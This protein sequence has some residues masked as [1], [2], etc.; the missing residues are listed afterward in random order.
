M[1][2]ITSVCVKKCF[3]IVLEVFRYVIAVTFIASGLLKGM[4]IE[5]TEQAVRG[6]IDLMGLPFDMIPLS[7]FSVLICVCEIII[8][9]LALIKRVF[10]LIHP[11]YTLIIGVFTFITYL[12]ITSPFGGLESCGCFGEI[13]HLDATETFVKNLCLLAISITL[14]IAMTHQHKRFAI[15]T[16]VVGVLIL[17]TSCNHFGL[18]LEEIYLEEAME[19]A[20]DNRSELEKVLEYF[21][22]EPDTMKQKAARF[23]IANMPFHQSYIGPGIE[24]YDSAYLKMSREPLEFRDSVFLMLSDN[25]DNNTMQGIAD[26]NN[27]KAEYLISHINET[28]DTW[29]QSTWHKYFSDDMFFEYVLPYRVFTEQVS[30]WNT[31]VKEEFPYLTSHSVRSKR[32]IM[33]EAESCEARSA[34]IV[35]TES[36]SNGKMRLLDKD[37][38]CVSFQIKT[39]TKTKKYIS[40][41][42]TTIDKN[43][44][45]G[46]FLNERFVGN[47]QLRPTYSMKF[48]KNSHNGLEIDLPSGDNTLTIQHK[49]GIVGLDYMIVSHI[50]NDDIIPD[51]DYSKTYYRLS[52]IAAG[53][54][55]AFDTTEVLK[56]SVLQSLSEERDDTRLRLDYQGYKCWS[57]CEHDERKG[58]L[59]L[60]NQYCLT[61]EN[62]NA[63]QYTFLNGNHQKWIILP[64]GNGTVRLMSKDS[65]LSLEAVTDTDGARRIVQTSYSGKD[66][67][68][69]KLEPCGLRK[70]SSSIFIPGNSFDWAFKVFDVTDRYEWIAFKGNIM[71]KGTSLIKG[72]TG[73]C[74]DEAAFTVLLCRSIG[75]PAAVDFTPHWANRSQSHL[76]SVLIGPDG[77]SIPF[78]MGCAP[79]DTAHYYHPYLKPKVF[80]HGFSLNRKMAD[81][82]RNVKEYPQLFKNSD[83]IDVAEEYYVTSD[84]VRDAPKKEVGNASMAYI[85]VFDNRE[86]VPVY[87]GKIKDGKVIFKSMV[88]NV[89]YMAA[90]YK[91]GRIRPFGNPFILESGGKVRDLSTKADTGETMT[92]LR[93]YPFMGKQ[94]HFN[95]RMSGGRFQISD[96]SDFSN[97]TTF[98]THE[99]IT[100][101]NWYDITIGNPK[102]SLFFRYI[103][104]NGSY[105][106]VNEIELYSTD[107]NKIEGMVIG[108]SGVSGK[109]RDKVFDGDILTGFEGESPDGHWIGL[110]FRKPET[111]ARLRYIP[112]NDGNCIEVGD[113]YELFYWHNGQW[114]SSGKQ[115]ATENVLKYENIPSGG[116]YV[117]KNLSK[118]HEER[119]FTYENGNQVWW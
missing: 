65:G 97:A 119:I 54:Y 109:T 108:T 30:D 93:K 41:R 68:R 55:L 101:G 10:R 98:H 111:V 59:C 12:N 37:D 81:D 115:K 5:A 1:N 3:W 47:V 26:I 96:R 32:G 70:E 86:W 46:L 72:T 74:R 19:K 89:A 24:Q 90:T 16:V 44:E 110:I 100:D 79:G 18:P 73:N 45:V 33:I 53:D 51:V 88:R 40:L 22:D 94:D 48:F 71:P 36:A 69:W 25:I 62:S 11:I 64:A 13:I 23:L 75:I 67:Q 21:E 118:G 105:C 84:V 104:P 7:I 117:L 103:G 14:N 38:A 15:L 116:L 76:W 9:I 35:E 95:G 56:K 28:C 31:S 83:F 61:N 50:E 29:R 77:K 113:E 42:Y 27:M 39:P 6:Y 85:C 2:N 4:S 60:E 52:N 43:A 49:T 112:R 107:G 82:F 102:K 92:L 20:D 106:N 8:G 57:I 80:R 58:Y 91:D 34:S 66:T 17:P 78:Y 87:Y 99:G 63:G 114:A